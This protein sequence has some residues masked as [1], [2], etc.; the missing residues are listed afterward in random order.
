MTE[1][2]KTYWTCKCGFQFNEIGC[3]ACKRCG[4]LEEFN[5]EKEK[6]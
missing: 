5:E 4:W 3:G 1:P 2:N 6:K